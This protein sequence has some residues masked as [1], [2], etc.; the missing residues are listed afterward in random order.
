[1]HRIFYKRMN[2][3]VIF[4]F[5]GFIIEGFTVVL[6]HVKNSLFCNQ[7]IST[8]RKHAYII[9]TPLNPTFI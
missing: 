3:I 5:K 8:S 2:I 7:T 9:L 4:K 6:I 1:M